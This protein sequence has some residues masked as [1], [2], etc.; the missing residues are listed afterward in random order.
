MY[1]L[2]YKQCKFVH[3]QHLNKMDTLKNGGSI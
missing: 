3:D 2:E 1:E